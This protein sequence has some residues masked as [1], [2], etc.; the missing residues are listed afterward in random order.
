M[1]KMTLRWKPCRQRI[2]EIEQEHMYCMMI[3]DMFMMIQVMIIVCMLKDA[4]MFVIY[5]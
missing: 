3:C 2:R 1:I 5:C 4:F